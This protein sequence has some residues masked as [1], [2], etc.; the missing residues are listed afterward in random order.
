MVAQNDQ[1]SIAKISVNPSA[2]GRLIPGDF[3]GLSIDHNEAS[4]WLGPKFN[5]LLQN[6]IDATGSPVFVRIEGD[7]AMAPNDR[8]YGGPFYN[9]CQHAGNSLHYPQLGAGPGTY[10]LM[11]PLK[12]FLQQMNVEVSLGVDMACDHPEWAPLEAKAYYQWLGPELWKKVVAIEIGNE[13][14][15]YPSQKFRSKDFQFLPRGDS[16]G[17]L[18]EWQS[19]AASIKQAIPAAKV[20]FL[21]PG[22]AGSSYIAGVL[23]TIGKDFPVKI[24]SQHN[25]PLPKQPICE[26]GQTVKCNP[27]DLL[28]QDNS[29]YGSHIGPMLYQ[30]F[31]TGVHAKSPGTLFRMAEFNDVGGGGSPGVSDTFQSALWLLDIEFLY[32]SLGYDGTNIH[33]G[34]YT[35]YSLWQLKGDGRLQFVKPKYYGLLAF[36]MAAGNGARLIPSTV[37]SKANIKSWATIDSANHVHVVI[38]NKDETSGGIV[39]VAVPGYTS[40]SG[41]LLTAPVFTAKCKTGNNEFGCASGVSLGEFTFDDSKDGKPVPWA[42]NHEGRHCAIDPQELCAQKITGKGYF[43]VTVPVTSALILDFHH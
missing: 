26:P 14:D 35:T 10:S 28:L 25:Y 40:G 43:T 30:N 29:V 24:V 32:A 7:G 37:D 19:L 13:P 11:E 42:A 31:V 41:T 33:T 8:D 18:A 3:A 9:N 22:T 1:R 36:D 12:G 6:L 16:Q 20:E 38:I 5:Q 17:Y 21:D 27:V 34:Q 2:V 15:N 23:S 39:N 4:R